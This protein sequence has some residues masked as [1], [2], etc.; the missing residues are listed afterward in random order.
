MAARLG[1]TEAV[2][3]RSLLWLESRLIVLAE[4]QQGDLRGAWATPSAG[5]QRRHT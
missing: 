2:I 3:R 1:T 4:W 5:P